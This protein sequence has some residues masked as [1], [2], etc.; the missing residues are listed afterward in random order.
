MNNIYK[1]YIK[2]T[3]NILNES[4]NFIEKTYQIS[5]KINN[6]FKKSNDDNISDLYEKKEKENINEIKSMMDDLIEKI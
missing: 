2:E 5:K 3:E 1:Q 6:K 4:E